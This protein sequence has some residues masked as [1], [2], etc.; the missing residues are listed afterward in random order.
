MKKK[1]KTSRWIGPLFIAWMILFIFLGFIFASSSTVRNPIN[2]NNTTNLTNI[3]LTNTMWSIK[4]IDYCDNI[5][6][7]MWSK[8]DPDKHTQYYR[9]G[10]IDCLD[11]RNRDYFICYIRPTK[12]TICY[13]N[14]TLLKYHFW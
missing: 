6:E 9:N 7:E 10:T 14:T 8:D 11:Y 12:E 13:G 2:N 3:N 1:A 4:K 5:Y